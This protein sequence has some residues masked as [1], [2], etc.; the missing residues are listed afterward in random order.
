MI[1]KIFVLLLL[2]L[3]DPVSDSCDFGNPDTAEI[4][5]WRENEIVV[6]TDEVTIPFGWDASDD[7]WVGYGAVNAFRMPV[8]AK[9]VYRV[10]FFENDVYTRMILILYH[11]HTPD[12]Y[13][14]FAFD[15]IEPY[16]DRNN[17]HFGLHPCKTFRLEVDTV[18]DWI[19]QVRQ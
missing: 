14:V 17:E 7:L 11:K 12:F 2:L 19:T 15:N 18:D 6:T 9:W 3:A 16:A 10:K 8:N 5:M 4:L 13:Y 1:K